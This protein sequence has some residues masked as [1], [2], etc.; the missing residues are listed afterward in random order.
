[1]D[2][3]RKG[4]SLRLLKT[5]L[6]THRW[7]AALMVVWFVIKDSPVWVLP[8]MV[9]ISIDLI[10]ADLTDSG[11]M[12]WLTIYF[13]I[14][15]FLL[16]QNIP[17]TVL[18]VSKASKIGRET[19]QQLRL[20]VCRQLQQLS[21]LYHERVGVGK[22]QAK[23]IR[24]I[25][26]VERLPRLIANTFLHATVI[27]IGTIIMTAVK[28]P[29]AVVLLVVM[30]PLAVCV[31][32][33]FQQRMRSRMHE[34]RTSVEHM[35]GGLN[36]MVRMVPI[37][38]AHGLEHQA[39]ADAKERIQEVSDRGQSWDVLTGWFNS[40]GWV[41]FSI[42]QVSFLA[43]S[44]WMGIKG[45]LGERPEGTI[46]AMNMYFATA[47]GAI[48]SLLNMLPQYTEA[49]E[50]FASV[51]EVLDAPDIEYNAKKQKTEHLVGR[52][53]FADVHYRYPS[54]DEPAVCGLSFE[55]QPNE[56]VAIVGPSGG[57]KSTTLSLLLGFLRPTAGQVIYDGVSGDDLDLRS[58]RRHVS[59]VTQTSFMFSGSVRDNIAY[60]NPDV[61]D[62]QIKKALQLAHGWDFVEQLPKG[63]HTQIGVGGQALSGGQMQRLALA[64]AFL[65]DPRVLILDEPTSSLDVESEIAVTQA[66]ETIRQGRT[67]IIVSHALTLARIADR[68]L[69]V[70]D[71]RIIDQGNHEELMKRD[72]FYSRANRSSIKLVG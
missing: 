39:M 55:V 65:R 70:E 47:N 29:I 14:L 12:T 57:G 34:Y 23:L 49:F 42:C 5:Y 31:R 25:E 10:S 8:F 11:K 37:A 71:G 7:D 1:M 3:R 33:F 48:L 30:I 28:A 58:Y 40:F 35:S 27:F 63:I 45:Y 2:T 13:G 16:F 72:N 36:E 46:T 38:R 4:S 26:A 15:L 69:I 51:E 22:L 52:I 6:D 41:S 59:V 20:Q 61:T 56:T 19:G 67:T 21:L 60:G 54:S 43:I 44:I 50:G 18:F 62:E 68:I 24:D 64:R 53:A 9:G 32:S 66:I 17:T